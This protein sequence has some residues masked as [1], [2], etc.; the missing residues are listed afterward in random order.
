MAFKTEH[1]QQL[2]ANSRKYTEFVSDAEKV[3]AADASKQMKDLVAGSEVL[4]IADGVVFNKDQRK[5]ADDELLSL[6]RQHTTYRH[7]LTATPKVEAANEVDHSV[8]RAGHFALQNIGDYAGTASTNRVSTGFYI[9]KLQFEHPSERI[10]SSL[11]TRQ[12]TLEERD[13]LLHEPSAFHPPEIDLT[14]LQ[15][16]PVSAEDAKRMEDAIRK[17]VNVW[18]SGSDVGILDDIMDPH[19]KYLDCYGLASSV[20][21]SWEGVKEGKAAVAAAQKHYKN[22]NTLVSFAISENQKVGFQHWRSDAHKIDSGEQLPLEG[23]GL[24]IFNDQNKI[25]EILEFTM[26]KYDNVKKSS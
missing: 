16:A 26:T 17:W 2:L 4:F 9:E 6:R 25:Q 14:R 7:L 15:N 11:I 23:V 3:F 1:S 12:M 20:G 22:S 21:A 18:S 24:I 5:S 8:F 13:H 19:V 10:V